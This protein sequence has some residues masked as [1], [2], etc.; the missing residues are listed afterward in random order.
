LPSPLLGRG[1]TAAFTPCPMLL[2]FF[3]LSMLAPRSSPLPL[4]LDSG[5][6][7][8]SAL[9]FISFFPVLNNSASRSSSAFRN[10][11]PGRGLQ[12]GRG[13]PGRQLFPTCAEQLP[14][15]RNCSARFSQL[16]TA[17]CTSLGR[18][19]THAALDRSRIIEQEV[20]ESAEISGGQKPPPSDQSV[21][22]RANSCFRGPSSQ[23][24]LR[25]PVQMLFWLTAD[26]QPPTAKNEEASSAWDRPARAHLF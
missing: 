7:N 22:A 14:D 6:A 16:A 2:A 15:A 9:P 8:F 11:W 18:V 20:A 26:S 10:S 19:P 13:E 24:P 23:R 17:E 3:R 25:P 21:F 1:F 4:A 5:L 12:N